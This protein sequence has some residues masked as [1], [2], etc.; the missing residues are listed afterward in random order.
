M[1]IS[2]STLAGIPTD[3]RQLY[4]TVTL[5][6]TTVTR[7][8]EWTSSATNKATVSSTG[9]VTLVANGSATITC[10]LEGDS[11]VNDTCAVTV[12]ASP[13]DY[14]QVIFSPDKNYILE[15]DTQAY[16]VYLYK[17]G[18]IQANVFDLVCSANAVPVDHFAF[19]YSGTPG[20]TF[21]IENVE[22][23]LS[24]HLTITC[25]SVAIASIPPTPQVGTLEI[26]LRGVW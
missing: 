23:Y 12:S 14:Y 18:T 11:S 20:N 2:E 25:T 15:G 24:D 5:N 19:S 3:T 16:A 22:K 17:N 10:N 7:T 1:T 21:S 13:S 8:V 9:L 26:N 4:A 6:G